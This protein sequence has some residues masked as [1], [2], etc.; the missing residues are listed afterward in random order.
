MYVFYVHHDTL[1]LT[2]PLHVLVLAL[3]ADNAMHEIIMQY[4]KSQN[5]EIC[6]I[7]LWASIL[8]SLIKFSISVVMIRNPKKQKESLFYRNQGS[9]LGGL[10]PPV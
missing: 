7:Y 10:N 1:N 3:I 4:T 6:D 9:N 5:V 8:I 2:L